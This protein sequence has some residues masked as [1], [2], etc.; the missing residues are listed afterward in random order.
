MNH[1][2]NDFFDLSNIVGA[3]G[4][5]TVQ[6]VG[7]P[8]TCKGDPLFMQ[9]LNKAWDKASKGVKDG[10]KDC[11]HLNS[12]GDI[13]RIDAIK[14]HPK[15]EDFVRTFADGKTYIGVG[16]WGGVPGKG[17]DDGNVGSPLHPTYM[18]AGSLTCEMFLSE[19]SRPR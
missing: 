1:Q 7:D 10:L 3:G 18:Y 13:V 6:Q 17:G 5:L 11:V 2:G 12:K 9:D 14:D 16:S 4:N 19:Q 15:L 8:S